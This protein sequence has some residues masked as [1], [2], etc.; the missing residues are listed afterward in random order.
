MWTRIFEANKDA[1][2]NPDVIQPGQMLNIPR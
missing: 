1:V 2:S